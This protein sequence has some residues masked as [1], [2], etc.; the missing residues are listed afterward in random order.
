LHQFAFAGSPL[1]TLAMSGGAAFPGRT[2]TLP[3]QETAQRFA[4][5]GQPFLLVKLFT[6]VMI[7]EAGILRACQ[8]QDGLPGGFG[9]A[10]VARPAAV[11]VSQR[12]LPLFAQTLL[13]AL[14]V[15]HAQGQELGGT[16]TRHVS[17]DA[18]ADHA[19]SL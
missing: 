5:H 12:R 11:G 8:P 19:H 15:A 3:A 10:S 17:L 1:T 2:E 4:A 13:Q 14:N 6:E 18:S 16:G 7:V 9:Q